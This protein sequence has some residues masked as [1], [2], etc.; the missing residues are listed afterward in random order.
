VPPDTEIIFLDGKYTFSESIYWSSP[1]SQALPDGVT[2]RSETYRGATLCGVP[3][4][5]T[6]DDGLAFGLLDV[7]RDLEIYGLNIEEWQGGGAGTIL[8]E[9]DI[10]GLR[11]I[12]NRFINN[13][14]ITQHHIVYF[15]GGGTSL[16]TTSREW[17]VECNDAILSAGSGA[18]ISMRNGPY[19]THTG[20]VKNNN[21][22]GEGTWAMVVSDIRV[23][24]TESN[25]EVCD[26]VFDGAFT[27][28]GIQFANYTTPTPLNGVDSTFVVQNNVINNQSTGPNAYAIWRW[29]DIG[30]GQ[31]EHMPT[32][33]NNQLSVSKSGAPTFGV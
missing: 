11:I 9:Q 23:A 10:Q 5:A 25:I 24:G 18:F 28:G 26:N 15:S 8:V 1:Q 31:Q 14:S 33:L 32:L 17:A 2:L 30:N 6:S 27:E 20:T 29:P 13:G 19:G 12:G 21:V 4:P 3:N 22:S 16:D 7:V